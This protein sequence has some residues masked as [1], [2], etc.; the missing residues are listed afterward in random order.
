METRNICIISLFGA[1]LLPSIAILSS[2][3]KYP[4]TKE[5]D[6]Q[7]LRRYLTVCSNRSYITNKNEKVGWNDT[8]SIYADN[9]GRAILVNDIPINESE[10][11]SG[12][13]RYIPPIRE[14][15][16]YNYDSDGHM[17]SAIIP[18]CTDVPEYKF[19]WKDNLV[20]DVIVTG[21]YYGNT[22]HNHIVYDMNV[23]S[24]RSGIA[25][26]MDL[27]DTK[28]LIAKYL[29]GEIGGYVPS[30]PISIIYVYN[31]VYKNDT[32]N[33]T[34]TFDKNNRLSAY[35]VKSHKINV[36]RHFD[37]PK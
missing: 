20:T 14:E 22:Q 31:D 6:G 10:P 18:C 9:K 19:V 23:N 1:F 29:T 34:N 25:L 3:N 36:S 24:P 15:Y 30:H 11:D 13:I 4:N 37:Y 21:D 26:F 35:S 33:F 8:L 32:L 2:C 27:F 16:E 17:I 5:Y 28:K 7:E 12:N